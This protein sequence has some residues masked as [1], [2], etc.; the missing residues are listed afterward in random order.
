MVRA[1]VRTIVQGM[2]IERVAMRLLNRTNETI[3]DKISNAEQKSIRILKLHKEIDLLCMVVR[4]DKFQ[5]VP[6]LVSESI[7]I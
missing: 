5:P 6:P 1:I 4:V 2:A 7:K 3:P